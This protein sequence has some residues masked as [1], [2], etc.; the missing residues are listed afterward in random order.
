MKDATEIHLMSELSFRVTPLYILE[1]ERRMKELE[2]QR[3]SNKRFYQNL[4][5]NNLLETYLKVTSP[6]PTITNI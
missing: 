3:E 1:G 5:D 2:M 4:I 6:K